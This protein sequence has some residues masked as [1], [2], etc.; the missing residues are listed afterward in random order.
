MSVNDHR[1]A[2]TVDE[3]EV[4]VGRDQFSSTVIFGNEDHT[5]GEDDYTD[6][7]DHDDHD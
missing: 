6:V 2:P 1:T 7:E 3:F 4:K 5:L